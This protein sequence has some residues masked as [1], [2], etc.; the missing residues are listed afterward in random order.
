MRFHGNNKLLANEVIV[1]KFNLATPFI[2]FILIVTNTFAQDNTNIIAEFRGQAEFQ[3]SRFLSLAEALPEEVYAYR[4]AEGVRSGGEVLLHVAF[5][6]YLLLSIGQLGLPEGMTFEFEPKKWE[7]QTTSKEEIIKVVEKSFDDLFFALENIKEYEFNEEI[8]TFIGTRTKRG[9]SL[10]LLAH[11]Q[12][13]LGQLITYA[14][15]NGIV[16]PWSQGE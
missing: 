3:K 14:R 6:N 11:N 1:K 2:L 4:P 15:I 16:P 7:A 10:A 12:E 5:G 9:F 13:H 8:E